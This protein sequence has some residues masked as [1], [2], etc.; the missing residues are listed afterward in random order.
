MKKTILVLVIFVGY[1]ATLEARDSSTYFI[2][3]S[4]GAAHKNISPA[5]N[6]IDMKFPEI[7]SSSSLFYQYNVVN[8]RYSI[9]IEFQN[10]FA[11]KQQD[12]YSAE[13]SDAYTML[14]YGRNLTKRFEIIGFLGVARSTMKTKK[15]I[16]NYSPDSL[17]NQFQ[18]LSNEYKLK[19]SA[20]AKLSFRYTIFKSYKDYFKLAI[21]AET[22]YKLKTEKYLESTGASRMLFTL[23]FN[24]GIRLR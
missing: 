15:Q 21:Q 11:E 5:F 2:H 14:G 24:L 17:F 20:C 6:T 22:L 9:L 18:F 4:Y 19:L 8:R 16:L 13:Y 10:Y 12:K 1:C 7:N 3:L 23:G